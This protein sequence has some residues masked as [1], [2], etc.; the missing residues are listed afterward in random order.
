MKIGYARVSAKWYQSEFQVSELEKQGCDRVWR[1]A[2]A[3]NDD[4]A[5]AFLNF[6]DQVGPDDTVIATRITS[7]AHSAAE[8]L[9]L[10]ERIQKKGAHFKSIAEPWAN[11]SGKDGE[12][13]ID[14]IRG[15]I[16]FEIAVA[17][18]KSRNVQNR[19]QTF[20]VSAGR[21]HKLSEQQKVKAL[22]LLKI[23]KS[24]AEI[25]RMLEVSRSTIS[26]LKRFARPDNN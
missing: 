13:V 15:M 20:G 6:L 18:M 10:L 5:Q 8:F 9:N 24:A 1:E 7:V 2:L 11:T 17:D 21:P 19:P 12:R 4:E 22:S 23:G 14:T 3:G 25:S 26:R 16:D